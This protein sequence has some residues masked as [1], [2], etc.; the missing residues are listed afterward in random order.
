M[1][2]GSQYEGHSMA[3]S[4]WTQQCSPLNNLG[5]HT[6]ECG[7]YMKKML[8]EVTFTFCLITTGTSGISS[9]TQY[10]KTESTALQTTTSVVMTSTVFGCWSA[11]SESVAC[12]SV[13]YNKV[14]GACQLSGVVRAE[15]GL[16]SVP[17]TNVD[18]YSKIGNNIL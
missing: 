16:D 13:N 10:F 15:V 18:V 12:K 9:Y 8:L 1:I 2:T 4:V 14:S 6:V 3:F 7:P 17:N 11:C 5:I